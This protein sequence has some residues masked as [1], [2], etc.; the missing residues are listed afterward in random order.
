MPGC[1]RFGRMRGNVMGLWF[2]VLAL[3]FLLCYLIT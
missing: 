2:G 1:A 3:V